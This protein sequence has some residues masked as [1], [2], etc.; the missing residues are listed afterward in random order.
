VGDGVPLVIDRARS[1]QELL[2]V[3]D[4]LGSALEG[5]R[6][7]S[8]QDGAARLET[9]APEDRIE[10]TAIETNTTHDQRFKGY[11]DLR[12][13]VNEGT[14]SLPRLRLPLGDLVQLIH[15][16]SFVCVFVFHNRLPN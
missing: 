8:T 4:P 10:E 16:G 2:G 5:Y 6:G 9:E 12:E 3:C 7:D 15:N 11:L 13:F 1:D 14:N